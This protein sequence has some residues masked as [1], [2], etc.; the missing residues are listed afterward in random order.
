M[1]GGRRV[2]AGGRG[3]VEAAEV[4]QRQHGVW[5]RG[6]GAALVLTRSVKPG[7]CSMG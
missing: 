2:W 1:P 6:G 7:T 4:F 5:Q 3:Q